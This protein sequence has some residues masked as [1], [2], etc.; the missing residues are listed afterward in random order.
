MKPVWSLSKE[1]FSSSK[2]KNPSFV[3]GI[4]YNPPFVF[5]RRGIVSLFTSSL[6]T[7]YCLPVCLDWRQSSDEDCNALCRIQKCEQNLLSLIRK[8]KTSL[9]NLPSLF[10]T[11]VASEISSSS[12]RYAANRYRLSNRN[13]TFSGG[14]WISVLWPILIRSMS[15]SPERKRG[16]VLSVGDLFSYLWYFFEFHTTFSLFEILLC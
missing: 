13:R 15:Q 9:K 14:G 11:Q 8:T 10:S 2:L 6:G 16:S 1:F 7:D 4:F 12:L 3:L 5:Q